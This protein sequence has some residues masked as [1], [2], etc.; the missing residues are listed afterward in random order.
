MVLWDQWSLK[1]R[2][3]L[4]CLVV[5]VGLYHLAIQVFQLYLV[6]P[7]CPL[8]PADPKVLLVPKA[9]VT[10]PVLELLMIL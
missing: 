7:D 10:Q 2:P 3:D 1:D 5:L 4:K 6:C 9:L 8:A